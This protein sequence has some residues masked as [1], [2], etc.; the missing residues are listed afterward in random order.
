M[1]P[2]RS[3]RQLQSLDDDGDDYFCSADNDKDME[4]TV[5]DEKIGLQ[6][7]SFMKLWSWTIKK[8]IYC[9]RLC[10]NFLIF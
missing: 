8:Y 4:E 10:L 9:L 6:G 1:F 2:R 3:S 5:E 7:S